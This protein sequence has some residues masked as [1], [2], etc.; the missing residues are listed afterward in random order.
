MF[1]REMVT[2]L[3]RFIVIIM[4][5]LSIYKTNEILLFMFTL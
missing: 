4:L 1:W 2:D 5:F 3:C